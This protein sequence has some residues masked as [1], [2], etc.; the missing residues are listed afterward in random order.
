MI[1]SYVIGI[2]ETQSVVKALRREKK[3]TVTIFWRRPRAEARGRRA[4]KGDCPQ[5]ARKGRR[6]AKVEEER[7]VGGRRGGC[8][9]RGGRKRAKSEKKVTVPTL[10]VVLTR[11]YIAVVPVTFSC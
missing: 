7:D 8:G 1:C 4:G 6:R 2:G 9:G 3:V 11:P 5:F 10:Y